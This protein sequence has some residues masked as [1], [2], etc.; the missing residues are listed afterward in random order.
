MS[1]AISGGVRALPTRENACVMPCANPRRSGGVQL[2]M[3]RV[4]TGNVAPSPTPS[5]RRTRYSD[6]SPP[7]RPVSAVADAQISP[8][9]NSVRRAPQTSPIQPP[10]IWKIA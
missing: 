6:V 8:Q 9:T 7:T 3:A 5:S 4:A 10:R 2:C 1:D